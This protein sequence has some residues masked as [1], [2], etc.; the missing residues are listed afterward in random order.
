MCCDEHAIFWD[1]VGFLAIFLNYNGMLCERK[2]E[3]KLPSSIVI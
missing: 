1:A 3:K 2:R